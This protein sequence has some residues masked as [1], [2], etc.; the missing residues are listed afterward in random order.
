[1]LP[2][3]IGIDPGSTSGLALLEPADRPR[4]LLLRVVPADLGRDAWA[5]RAF[6]AFEAM[7]KIAGGRPVVGWY[8]LTCPPPGNGWMGN[9]ALSMRRGQLLGHASDAG[10]SLASFDHVMV[11]SW[12][13]RLGLPGKK[14]GDGGHRIAEAERL[15]EM[16]PTA[17]RG[18]GAG[19]VDAA[20]S[21]LI[22]CARAWA[23]T[24]RRAPKAPRAKAPKK[25]RMA[26]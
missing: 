17:L 15:V 9:N 6:L 11:Q 14:L 10:L 4:L 26:S 24:E 13:S 18:L 2:L 3:V 21:I 16:E 23:L 1:M 22:G 8:E 12:T 19:A 7:A 20:E 5:E 25:P